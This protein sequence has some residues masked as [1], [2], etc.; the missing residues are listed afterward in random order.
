MVKA[1]TAKIEPRLSREATLERSDGE[2]EPE[3]CIVEMCPFDVP[4]LEPAKG[5]H[6]GLMYAHVDSPI[7]FVHIQSSSDSSHAQCRPPPLI[8]H[9]R[10]D[11]QTGLGP[12]APLDSSRAPI[13]RPQ[14]SR[15][16]SSSLANHIP[17]KRQARSPIIQRIK[18]SGSAELTRHR[19]APGCRSCPWPN[20]DGR[21]MV[22]TCPTLG[23]GHPLQDLRQARVRGEPA[24]LA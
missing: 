7:E 18:P 2:H 5:A 8:G 22:P 20:L 13:F 19:C 21:V 14:S 10:A 3:N 9:P 15:P 6:R 4:V 24:A 23:E 11:L 12:R 17:S 1:E 16:Q